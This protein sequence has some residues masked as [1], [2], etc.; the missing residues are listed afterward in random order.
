LGLI[1][2]KDITV[3]PAEGIGLGPQARERAIEDARREIGNL[4]PV[5]QAA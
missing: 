3:I 4:H 2:L 1:G 5:R